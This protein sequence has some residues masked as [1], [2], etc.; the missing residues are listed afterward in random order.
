MMLESIDLM[1]LGTG[2]LV[3]LSGAML[4]TLLVLRGQAMSGDAISHAI[5]LGI[6]V[7][8]M[9]TGAR[10]GPIVVGGA[11]LAGLVAVIGAQALSRSGLMGH[12]AAIG[13]VFPAMFA[14]G[15]L[16]INLNARNLHL[17]IDTVLLGEIGFVWLHT[18][19]VLGVELPVAGVTLAVVGAVNAVFLLM[20][21]KEQKLAA[22]DPG[23]A[24]A[25]GFR[26]QAMGMA[27]LALTS[28]T[29]VAS[30]DAVGVVLFL[31]FLIVPAVTGRL[32]AGSVLGIMAIAVVS[33]V[34]SVG[35]GY[36]A[37]VRWDVSIGGSMA[38]AT[39]LG[40]AL[41]LA[42]SP[43]SGVVAA[44]IRA[45]AIELEGLVATLLTHLAAH[46]GTE[47]QAEECTPEAL[48]DHLGWSETRAGKVVLEALDRGVIHRAGAEL[49]LTEAGWA[50]ARAAAERIDRRLALTMAAK[51][52][53]RDMAQDVARDTGR[54]TGRDT[55]RGPHG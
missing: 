8:W 27:L 29:A 4:G 11:A 7:A 50:L 41:A 54:D 45:R 30:F 28:A 3:A 39:G 36:G 51:E 20:F 12:D 25:L 26:P 46:E 24:A 22:F 43:R 18:V 33:G 5:V 6:V 16:L 2:A 13:L 23:L 15:V 31:A 53:A 42:L 52:A 35:V 32:I 38:L 1:I 49:E 40:L 10:A 9:L 34:V 37:A 19:P 47:A 17:D 55:A 14:L 48:V 21:W 44:L